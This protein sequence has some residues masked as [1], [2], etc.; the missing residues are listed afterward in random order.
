MSF[1][2]WRACCLEDLIVAEELQEKGMLPF[3]QHS[4]QRAC[5]YWPTEYFISENQVN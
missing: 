2:I 3:G 4:V 5:P 1:G